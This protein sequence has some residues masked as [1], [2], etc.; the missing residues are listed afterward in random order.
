MA[1]GNNEGLG[2]IFLIIMSIVMIAIGVG[3]Y[4][5]LDSLLVPGLLSFICS[6]VPLAAFWAYVKFV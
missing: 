2:N 5:L 6:L 4:F 3:I 1:N